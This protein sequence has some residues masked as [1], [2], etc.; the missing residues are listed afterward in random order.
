MLFFVERKVLKTFSKFQKTP[1]MRRHKKSPPDSSDTDKQCGT[2]PKVFR[3]NCHSNKDSSTTNVSK[4]YKAQS[5]VLI[6]KK[7]K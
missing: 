2:G 4:Y 6:C 1:P 7:I 3:N 5:L